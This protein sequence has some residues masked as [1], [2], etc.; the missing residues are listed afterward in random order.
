LSEI[1][2][3]P[4]VFDDRLTILAINLRDLFSFQRLWQPGILKAL[5]K[6]AVILQKQGIVDLIIQIN[7]G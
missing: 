2:Q 5:P 3:K 7:D 4:L 1:G 6:L